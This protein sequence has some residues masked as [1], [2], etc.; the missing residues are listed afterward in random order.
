MR[1][2]LS[3]IGS[4]GDVQP[5]LALA[6]EL[7]GLG[8]QVRLCAPPDFRELAEFCG[9]PFVPIG[10]EVHTASAARP[11]RNAMPSPESLQRSPGGDHPAPPGERVLVLAPWPT[12]SEPS[13][14]VGETNLQALLPRVAAIVHHGGAGTTT[15]AA[16]SGVPQVVVPRIY[17]QFYF[18]G[19]VHRLGIGVLHGSDQPTARSLTEALKQILEPDVAARARSFA[20]EVRTDG[21]SIAAAAVS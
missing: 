9:L 10:P 5:L 4:R 15:T 2:L 12:P 20:A 3:T 14:F 13:F 18:A 17:D 16:R 21:A 11:A 1:V 6:V 19:R 8:R 7:R